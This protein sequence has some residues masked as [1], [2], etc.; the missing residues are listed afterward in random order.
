MPRKT[1]EE[2]I[3]LKREKRIGGIIQSNK[4][5]RDP[6]YFKNNYWSMAAWDSWAAQGKAGGCSGCGVGYYSATLHNKRRTTMLGGGEAFCKEA[7]GNFCCDCL[8]FI[9]IKTGIKLKRY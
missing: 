6:K 5:L 3:S 2:L 9:E 1:K 7:S 4:F 8:N